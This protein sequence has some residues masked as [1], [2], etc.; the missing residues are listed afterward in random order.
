MTEDSSKKIELAMS[1]IASYAYSA[2]TELKSGLP[3][4]SCPEMGYDE[5]LILDIANAFTSW[6]SRKDRIQDPYCV[7]FFDGDSWSK[8]TKDMYQEDA[9]KVWYKL[10][11]GGRKMNNQS[12]SSYYHLGKSNLK[13]SGRHEEE[14]QQDDFS[15]KYL[16]AKSF[17]D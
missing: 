12:H 6:Q 2:S 15:I 13:L 4:G 5:Q 1:I 17:G 3:N 9:Y 16:L 11:S 8:V 7:W 10:T 14:S